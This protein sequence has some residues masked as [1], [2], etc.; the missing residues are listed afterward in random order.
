MMTFRISTARRSTTGVRTAATP[1]PRTGRPPT[2]LQ[3]ARCLD[4]GP[5]FAVVELRLDQLHRLGRFLRQQARPARCGNGDGPRP[6]PVVQRHHLTPLDQH[7]ASGTAS[8]RKR[9]LAIDSVCRRRFRYVLDGWYNAD[10]ADHIHS[11]FGGLPVRCLTGSSS[12]HKF[13]QATCNNFR[14]S[15]LAVDGIWG[16][17]PES[18]F[19][20]LMSALGVTGDPHT[21]TSVYQN[22]SAE[23]PG[24]LRQPEHLGQG[25]WRPRGRGDRAAPAGRS[26]VRRRSGREA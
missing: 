13:V 9:Y 8:L 26:S 2:L 12:R 23:S 14:G 18:A 1:P 5:A 4:P 3:R 22:L 17:R 10:H 15:G 19:N 6:R 25:A 24:R 20:G 21:T 11:D 7:H 16:P